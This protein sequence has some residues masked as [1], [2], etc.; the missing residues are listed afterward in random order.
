VTLNGHRTVGADAGL[1]HPA[2]ARPG[3][4][5]NYSPIAVA[6]PVEAPSR[7]IARGMLR[8]GTISWMVT[9]LLAVVASYG[10][11]MRLLR[12]GVWLAH[13]DWPGGVQLFSK[14]E[15]PV[16]VVPPEATGEPAGRLGTAIGVFTTT[17]W[18]SEL[19][20]SVRVGGRRYTHAQLARVTRIAPAGRGV[21]VTLDMV[22][23]YALNGGDGQPLRLNRGSVAVSMATYTGLKQALRRITR[24]LPAVLPGYAALAERQP[25]DPLADAAPLPELELPRARVYSLVRAAVDEQDRRHAEEAAGVGQPAPAPLSLDDDHN[26]VRHIALGRLYRLAAEQVPGAPPARILATIADAYPAFADEC[27]RRV[28]MQAELGHQ[29]G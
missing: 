15:Y 13:D 21:E 3:G 5:S 24:P 7:R 29:D 14:Q 9:A 18:G 25:V 11:L 16:I 22:N 26:V 6:L 4:P 17:D 12:D 1:H 8:G 10:A 19:P 20:A 23:E 27:A 28:A 2:A